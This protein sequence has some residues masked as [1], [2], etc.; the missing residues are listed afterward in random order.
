M[1]ELLVGFLKWGRDN[2]LAAIGVM[3]LL[4]LGLVLYEMST[5]VIPVITNEYLADRVQFKTAIASYAVLDQKLNDIRLKYNASRVG[6]MRFHDGSR[7]VSGAAFYFVTV[8]TMVGVEVDLPSI[9]DLNA[10][11]FSPVYAN[12]TT[13]KPVCIDTSKLQDGP[14][15]D[16]EK[17]RG[18]AF[19]CFFPIFD[20][21][22][23]LAGFM[24]VSW[25][26]TA[27]VPVTKDLFAMEADIQQETAKLSGYFLW[28]G[29]T[30]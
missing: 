2:L 13:N 1:F 8:A 30:K 4:A 27:D 3:V 12:L 16:L 17:K 14:L 21:A 29:G 15:K 28:S 26:D 25:L 10:S 6:L 18:A 22:N 11:I 5:V 23:N 24:I 9:T 20:L 7:D 19:E